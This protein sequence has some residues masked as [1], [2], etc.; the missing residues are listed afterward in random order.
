ME[1][2]RL[3]KNR[4]E[5]HAKIGMV[6]G[7]EVRASDRLAIFG[8]EKVVIPGARNPSIHRPGDR[9]DMVERALLDV[10]KMG[11]D[12]AMAKKIWYHMCS[13]QRK[14]MTTRSA[15]QY[16]W[17]DFGTFKFRTI[18]KSKDA[19]L[20][21]NRAL[22]LALYLNPTGHS[23]RQLTGDEYIPGAF[24]PAYK[25]QRDARKPIIDIISLYTKDEILSIRDAFC[26]EEHYRIE[27][28]VDF[29][30]TNKRSKIIEPRLV[31]VDYRLMTLIARVLLFII[32]PKN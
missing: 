4:K 11:I 7:F 2:K 18:Y 21:R 23:K 19:I 15:V 25:I 29:V 1:K 31:V 27:K 17:P 8:D 28:F 24:A 26:K 9:T 16:M 5:S 14:L 10:Q 12:P 13:T 20:D 6:D 3:K 30:F 32:G 22:S